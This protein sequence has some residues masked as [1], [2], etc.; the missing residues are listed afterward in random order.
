MYASSKPLHC[1]QG[2]T[3]IVR[4]I[5]RMLR[6]TQR[7]VGSTTNNIVKTIVTPRIEF[8]LL[9]RASNVATILRRTIREIIGTITNA[10]CSEL[11]DTVSTR[12]R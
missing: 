1:R 8:R 12:R 5:S 6:D 4:L 9:A 7:T 3:S 10:Q 11:L 2:E